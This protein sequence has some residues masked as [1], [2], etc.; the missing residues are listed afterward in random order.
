MVDPNFFV[1]SAELRRKSTDGRIF[2]RTFSARLG[3][4]SQKTGE[5]SV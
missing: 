2:L 3:E 1:A 4:K 5:K